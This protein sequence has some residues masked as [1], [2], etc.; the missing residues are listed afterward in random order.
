MNPNVAKISELLSGGQFEK[1]RIE[2]ARTVDSDFADQRRSVECEPE[3]SKIDRVVFI[4]GLHRS[5]T[6]L[7]YDHLASLFDFSR[8][9]G[10]GVPCDEGQFLQ[11]VYPLEKAFGGPGTF[12]FSQQISKLPAGKMQNEPVQ[13]L[14][15]RVLAEWSAKATHSASRVLLEKSPANIVRI[16]FLRQLFPNS[17]FIIWT[18]D[19]RAVSMATLKWH[20]LPVSTHMW[21]WH[22]AYSRALEDLESDCLICRYEAFCDDPVSQTNAIAKFVGVQPREIPQE[23]KDKFRT[24]INTNDQYVD[25]FPKN[26][27]LFRSQVLMWELFGYDIPLERKQGKFRKRRAGLKGKVKRLIRRLVS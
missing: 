9:Q 25:K 21:H 1:A 10:T 7:L 26:E 5:G 3:G 12:A 11:S 16:G 14:G 4:C 24:I 2:L 18:R 22:C 20:S 27:C 19:P 8:F 13:E 17:K 6:T 15:R 23:T